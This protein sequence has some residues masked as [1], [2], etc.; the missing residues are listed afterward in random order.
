MPSERTGIPMRLARE[1]TI[2]ILRRVPSSEEMR[3]LLKLAL[4]VLKPEQLLG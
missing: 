1:S 4:D 3:E 2:F